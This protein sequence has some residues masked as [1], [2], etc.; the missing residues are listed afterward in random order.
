MRYT[1]TI[2][3]FLVC[4]GIGLQASEPCPKIIRPWLIC[5]PGTKTLVSTIKDSKRSFTIGVDS[6]TPELFLKAV[7][8]NDNYICLSFICDSD[9]DVLFILDKSTN[10]EIRL[11]KRFQYYGLRGLINPNYLVISLDDMGGDDSEIK[12]YVVLR[13]S[14]LKHV[15][16]GTDAIDYDLRVEENNLVGVKT[17]LVNGLYEKVPYTASIHRILARFKKP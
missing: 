9:S 2:L 8:E 12:G 6:S 3:L 13:L 14:D 15:R 7:H 16:I 5:N 11:G 1:A 17:V 10:K 4:I